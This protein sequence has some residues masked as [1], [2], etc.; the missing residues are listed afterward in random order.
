MTTSA[1]LQLLKE[2]PEEVV[3]DTEHMPDCEPDLTALLG[4]SVSWSGFDGGYLPVNHWQ[5]SAS[6]VLC[7]ILSESDRIE[8]TK[9][10]TVKTLNGWNIEHD[11]LWVDKC[12]G[13]ASKWHLDGRVLWY[14]TDKVQKERGYSLKRAQVELLGWPEAGD[15]ELATSVA[16][17][18]GSLSKGQ[19]YLAPLEVLARYAVKDAES[20][21]LAIQTIL[22]L[23]DPDYNLL[24]FHDAN[25]NYAAFLAKTEQ[26]GV[27]CDE[28]ALRRAVK[29]YQAEVAKAEANI[30]IVCATEIGQLEAQWFDKRLEGY[31]TARGM[32]QFEAKP[33]RHP[34]FNPNSSKQRALLFHDVIGLPVLERTETGLAKMDKNTIAGFDHPAARSFVEVSENEKLLQFANQYLEH[35]RSGRIHFPHD[36]VATVSERLGG[37]APYDLNMP[38]GSKPIMSAFSAEPGK[39]GIHMDLVSVEPCLIAGFSSDE[40]M[41]KVYRDGLGDIYLDLCLDLFPIEEANQYDSETAK[42]IRLFHREYDPNQPPTAETKERF[43]RLR[44]VSKI[45]QL[46]VGY[47]GTAYTVSRNLNRAGFSTSVDKAKVLVD[48]YWVKF[49]RIRELS[50]KLS[51]LAARKGYIMGLY[52]RRLYVPNAKRKDALNRFAQ[53]GGHAILR[54]IV[55]EIDRTKLPG[56]RPLLPDIHDSTSWE[57]DEGDHEAC[58]GIFEAAIRRVNAD[59]SLPVAVRGEIKQFHTFYGLKNRE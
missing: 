43:A 39:I 18:G 45:I 57:C 1:L 35:C 6:S 25:T 13:I 33:Q 47:T 15:Q 44:K 54:E 5:G 4:I 28:F 21:K 49:A 55:L 19:H 24:K 48:R 50:D 23:A 17:A 59:L 29:H 42:L 34:K 8:L 16:L 22:T 20:T 46:A 36:T 58:I 40:A 27:L 32:A 10:L 12:F 7:R 31:K 30:R 52:G 3:L 37:Y 14:L 38:F 9:I 51:G 41:L 56:M 26:A 2:A 11:R 53:H